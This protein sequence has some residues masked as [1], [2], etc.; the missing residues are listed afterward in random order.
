MVTIKREASLP[1]PDPP[2]DSATAAMVK[3]FE[4]Y[5][6]ATYE[7]PMPVMVK[8]EGCYLWDVENRQYLDFMS[9]IAVNSLG[10]CEPGV[11]RVVAQQVYYISQGK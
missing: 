6:V 1:N 8:G 3:G 10:H 5:M 9:G 2:T 4:P 11:S 7:R